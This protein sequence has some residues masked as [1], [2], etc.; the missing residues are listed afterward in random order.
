MEEAIEAYTKAPAWASFEEDRQGTLAPGKL[1]DIAV[2]DRHL[3][4]VGNTRPAELLK[5]R[6][7]YTIAGGKVVYDMLTGEGRRSNAEGRSK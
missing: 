7:R 5:A 3:I 6:V 1:A 2:F 4:E